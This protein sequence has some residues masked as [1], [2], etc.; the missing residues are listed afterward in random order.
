MIRTSMKQL[1]RTP[2]KTVFLLLMVIVTTIF[3]SSG[4]ILLMINQQNMNELE[5][6]FITIGTVEQSPSAIKQ[7]NR[8]DAATKEYRIYQ[9]PEYHEILPISIVDLE[10]IDFIEKPEKRPYYGSYSPEYELNYH[11]SAERAV[12]IAEIT[13]IETCIPNNPVKVHVKRILLG[14]KSLEGTEIPICAHYTENP[15]CIYAEKT[16]VVKLSHLAWHLFGDAETSEYVPEMIKTEQYTEDGHLIEDKNPDLKLFHEISDGFYQTDSG[17]RITELVK[18]YQMLKDTLPVTATNKTILLQPFYNNDVYVCEGRDI[19]EEEYEEGAKVCLIPKT[20]AEANQI[21]IGE[22]VHLQLYNANYRNAAG[23]NYKVNGGRKWNFGHL[24]SEGK[25]Y[26]IFEDGQYKVV[27]IYNTT[28]RG[29]SGNY[30]IGSNEIIIPSKSIENS[31]ANHIV[32]VGP[33]KGYN[34]SFQIPNGSIE[35][36]MKT[37]N[38]YGYEDIE[39]TFY[40]KGYSNI[41]TGL[42]NIKNMSLL[43]LV[44]GI[45]LMAAVL[46]LFTY[47]MIT[48]ERKRI[49]IERSLGMSKRSCVVSLMSGVLLLLVIGS[50]VGCI[51]GSFLSDIVLEQQIGRSYYS[52]ISIEIDMDR[53]A[54]DQMPE[55]KEYV[56]M[57]TGSFMLTI[58][59]V[60]L[61]SSIKIKQIIR[62][63]PIQL[64]MIE[65][66]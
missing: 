37:W 48:K 50:G 21:N 38:T 63:E 40:D 17:V 59:Y 15:E 10:E 4:A 16:Y 9:K 22:L 23:E 36:F 30:G 41:K 60:L 57:A 52:N 58:I 64:V 27:G 54:Q 51:T 65:K 46:Q 8:W 11:D 53:L 62:S 2:V 24:N 28:M 66:E 35:E 13:P 31:S 3:F 6:H 39:I 20:F 49:L 19:E 45:V 61:I 26:D 18:N 56:V 29:T 33:M 1:L 43:L 47:I 25:A 12:L 32:D 42:N 55:A 44:I 14:D 5:E 34:T 7:E